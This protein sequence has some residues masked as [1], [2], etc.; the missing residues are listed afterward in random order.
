MLAHFFPGVVL[1]KELIGLKS[2][3][4]LVGRLILALFAW[5][6]PPPLHPVL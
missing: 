1:P 2:D 6:L 3:K 5:Q 4:L